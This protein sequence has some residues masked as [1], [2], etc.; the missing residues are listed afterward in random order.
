MDTGNNV[1][2]YEAVTQ[3]HSSRHSHVRR[4][5]RPAEGTPASGEAQARRP[6]LATVLIILVTAM[7]GE[8]RAQSA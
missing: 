2:G 3:L 8:R 6:L 7:R 5:P 1:W 4:E